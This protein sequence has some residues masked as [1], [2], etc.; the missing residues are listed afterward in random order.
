MSDELKRPPLTHTVQL[1]DK[2]SI[3]IKLSYGLF[4]D[5]QRVCPDPGTL[6]EAGLGDPFAR[7]FIV[8]RCFT[9]T[10]KTIT[11]EKDMTNQED[12]P[13]EDPEEV[14]K[15]ISWVVGHLL[16]FFARSAEKLRLMGQEFQATLGP[17]PDQP[18]PSNDGSPASA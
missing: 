6:M 9:D 14:E 5:L 1:E 7:D 11:D 18:L 15:L 13:I 4:N 8:R 10:K 17:L 2:K 3:E 12:I 16:Y